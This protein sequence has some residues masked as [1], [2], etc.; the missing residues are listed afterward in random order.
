MK[1]IFL[2]LILSVISTTASAEW[3]L[4]QTSDDGNLYVDFDTLQK[5]DNLVTI[6]T[7]NDFY[8]RQDKNELST[9]W[10]EMHD[11]KNKRFKALNIEYYAEKMGQGKVIESATFDEAKTAWSD[12]V[13]YSVGE[14]KT[15]IICSR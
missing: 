5:T 15:N 9:K 1:R 8:N 7:L 14:L 12:V 11:C 3:T 10:R 4:I 2:V 6:S 13:Q